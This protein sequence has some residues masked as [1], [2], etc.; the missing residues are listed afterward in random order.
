MKPRKNNQ[1]DRASRKF[2]DR[3]EPRKVFWEEFETISNEMA[4]KDSNIHVISYYG[5]GGVGKTRLIK[6]LAEEMDAKSANYAIYDLENGQ[7]RINVLQAISKILTEKYKFVFPLFEYGKYLYMSKLGEDANAPEATVLLEKNPVVSSIKKALDLVP[8][9]NEVVKVAELVDDIQ[10]K[11]RTYAQNNQKR[12]KSFEYLNA[13][14]LYNKLPQLFAEDLENSIEKSGKPLV[15]LLDTYEKLVNELIQS[16]VAYTNDKWLR[17]DVI[18]VVPNVLWVICGREYLNWEQY[19]VEWKE[20]INPHLL[21]NL[22][23]K[24]TEE[25]LGS[26]GITDIDLCKTLYRLTNGT[27]LYLD[28]CVDTYLQF[29]EQNPGDIPAIEIFGKN[30]S[31]LVERFIRYMDNNSQELVFTLICLDNWTDELI[32]NIGCSIYQNFNFILYDKIKN[33][34]FIICDNEKYYVHKTVRE[35]L[36]PK[37]PT[38]IK[39]KVAEGIG[40]KLTP[41]VQ[42]KAYFSKNYGDAL[43]HITHAAILRHR[44]NNDDLYKYVK[45]NIVSYLCGY[46]E[47]GFFERANNILGSLLNCANN[48]ESSLFF[49][50]IALCK[51]RIELDT[52]NYMEALKQ[53]EIAKDLYYNT[54]GETH[55]ST[56]R[57][58]SNFATALRH[59]GRYS[60]SLKLNQQVFN[61]YKI[62][63]GEDHPDTISMM[64]NLAVS[65][66]DTGNLRDAL[67]MK[68]QVF[69]K[70]KILLGEDHPDTITA[71]FNLSI[72][73][74][75]LGEY[76]KALKIKHQVLEVSKKNL[77]ENHPNTIRAMNNLAISFIHLAQYQE[78]ITLYQHILDKQRKIYRDDHPEIINVMNN[79]A[80]ALIGSENYQESMKMYKEILEKYRKSLGDDHANTITALSNLA[81][82]LDYLGNYDEAIKMQEQVLDMRKKIFGDDHADTI[83]ALSNLVVFLNNAK[84]YQK[85]LEV[86]KQVLEKNKRIL[87]ENHPN[88]TGA[89]GNLAYTFIH[90]GKYN[91]AL[92]I[93]N[94]ILEKNKKILGEEHPDT[95][96]TIKNLVA[97]LR[98]LGRTDEANAIKE[99][100]IV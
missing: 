76:R 78:A 16:G 6:K 24:D 45:T 65:L 66:C 51:S 30:T 27:P 93:Y 31:E 19:D 36:L 12:F 23:V 20:A 75:D 33:L 40:I 14:E 5:I 8:V 26:E 73:L 47:A 46:S 96:K 15:I 28:I 11:V 89:M 43:A 10:S 69:E 4:I 70:R 41:L 60:E 52:G 62:V 1:P 38:Q 37:C 68:Q 34:S 25:F 53:A 67:E 95:I 97:L 48:N 82:T 61:N 17:D 92:D 35:I 22:S 74:D 98:Q 32:E 59:L 42:S 72:T 91:E 100:L 80:V 21:G 71:M 3:E 83:A 13:K 9:V 49:A 87:G 77:G 85:A 63:F 2:Q 56:I 44:N 18:A 88:T 86:N 84:K 39:N 29:K 58:T 81:I 55:I 90:L 64:N 54:L 50:E 79:L 57:A 99:Q 7:D 94:Q